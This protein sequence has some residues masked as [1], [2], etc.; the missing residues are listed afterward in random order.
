MH[1]HLNTHTYIHKGF[2]H[3]DFVMIYKQHTYIGITCTHTLKHTHVHI[4]ASGL[5]IAI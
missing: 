4:Y 1:T 5:R 3:C 2:A